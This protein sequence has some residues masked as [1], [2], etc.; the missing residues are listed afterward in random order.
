MKNFQLFQD[1]NSRP[2]KIDNR[3]LKKLSEAENN[4]LI[5]M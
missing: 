1:T 4:N 5:L 3:T 2:N